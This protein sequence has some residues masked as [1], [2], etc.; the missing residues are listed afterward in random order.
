MF[1]ACSSLKE[2]LENVDAQQ[3][4]IL[5]KKPIFVVLYN[6]FLTVL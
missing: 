4:V 3:S 6:V 2:L 5:S 1:F